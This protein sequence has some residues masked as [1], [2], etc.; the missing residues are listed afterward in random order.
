[1]Y[2][3]SAKIKSKDSLGIFL[4]TSKQ[5]AL[6]NLFFRSKVIYKKIIRLQKDS[7]VNLGLNYLDSN[8]VKILMN[9]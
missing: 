4:N 1:L 9:N 2:G 5:S 7:R 3:G 6:I 8:C